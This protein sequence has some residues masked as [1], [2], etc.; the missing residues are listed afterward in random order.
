MYLIVPLET[1]AIELNF[2]WLP[3]WLGMDSHVK[4]EIEKILNER[5]IGRELIDLTLIEAHEM[6]I[7]FLEDRFP[8]I[9]G[10]RDYLDGLKYVRLQ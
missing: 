4:K 3:T 10:L 2:M 8:E 1:G 5:L 7:A 6:V 9:H